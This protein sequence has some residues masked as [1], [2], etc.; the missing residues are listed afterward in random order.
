MSYLMNVLIARLTRD[1]FRGE[2]PKGSFPQIVIATLALQEATP[3]PFAATD[4]V[5]RTIDLHI[6]L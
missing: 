2:A 6:G 3:E 5:P 4:V 1:L